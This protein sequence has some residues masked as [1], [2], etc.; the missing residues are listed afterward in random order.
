[1]ATLIVAGFHRSGTSLLTELLHSAGLFVGDDLLGALPSNPYGHFEDREVMGLHEA[2]LR[3]NGFNW[4]VD[5]VFMPYVG[6][7]RW[8]AMQSFVDRR[9]ARH[10]L[11]GFKDPRVCFFLPVWHHLI[12]EA[13]TVILYR[14][15]AACVSSL[16]RRQASDLMTHR[17]DAASH[18]RF[19]AE[20]DFGLRMWIA[21]NRPLLE[22]ATMH[23]ETTLVLSFTALS[24]GFPIVDIARDRWGIPL[25]STPTTTVFDPGVATGPTPLRVYDRALLDDVDELLDAFEALDVTMPQRKE[26][27]G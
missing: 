10:L 15:P 26:H 7:A 20:P 17:G 23:P 19:W 6:P 25:A 21:H 13:K 11:W 14:E 4:Q 9:R 22:F 3:D 12:P 2:V 8:Q 18:R 1:M 27:S 16:H 24:E 5:R